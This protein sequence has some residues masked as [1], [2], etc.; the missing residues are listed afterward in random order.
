M[1]RSILS[2]VKRIKTEVA[3]F[4][5][6]DLIRKVCET[7]GHVWRERV[8]D[9]ATTVR[10]FALQILHGNTACSHVPRLGAVD[11]T[12]EAYCQARARLP[13]QVLQFLVRALS[14]FLGASP[15]VNE[16]RWH[17]HRTFLTDGSSVSM[18]DTPELQKEFGQPGVQK[19]GCGFPVMHLLA[20]FDA[21]TGFLLNVAGAPLRTHDMSRIGQVHPSLARRRCLGRRSRLLLL[22]APGL[23][24]GP[25]RLWRVSR[26]SKAGATKNGQTG[27]P[28]S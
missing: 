15:M 28:F 14:Q 4:L 20:L 11:C 1:A 3:Q 9:P 12:G 16:G 18:P 7:V 23:A 13:L 26:A 25:Q 17:G 10:L 21:A 27:T 5:K 2:A 8:L 19:P 22:R 24:R 6:A